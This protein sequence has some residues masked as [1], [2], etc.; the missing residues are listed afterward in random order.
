MV[1]AKNDIF[2]ITGETG[3]DARCFDAAG[4]RVSLG[5]K[6]SDWMKIAILSDIYGNDV[7]FEA[8]V[9]DFEK[10]GADR[11]VFLGNLVAK[12]S[13]PQ[14]CFDRM[15]GLKPLLWLKGSTEFWLD[16]AMMDVMPNTP[17]N[18][19]LLECYDYLVGHMDSPSMDVLMALEDKAPLTLGHY[20]G[21]AC[22]GSLRSVTEVIDP[23]NHGAALEAML[24]DVA[25]AFVLSGH[26]LVP[27]DVLFKGVRMVNPGSVGVPEGE[28]GI[29]RYA[30]LEVGDG[31]Q[32]SLKTVAYDGL[33]Y[34]ALCG[35]LEFPVK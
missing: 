10:E 14:R 7:A 17:D 16:S 24:K 33:R 2:L 4:I 25:P 19:Y 6:V 9:R 18:R 27:Y 1:W 15:K 3:T 30:L 21:L 34:E 35:K 5:K 29:A 23:L 12:G 28:A 20:S 26:G 32:V 13:E 11:V 8:V 31:F 22:H